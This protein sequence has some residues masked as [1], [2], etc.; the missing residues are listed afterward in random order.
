MCVCGRM[1]VA[2]RLVSTWGGID[3]CSGAAQFLVQRGVLV[4]ALLLK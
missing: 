3:V 4:V 2:L 1:L